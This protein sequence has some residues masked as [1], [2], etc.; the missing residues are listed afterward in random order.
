M[1]CQLTKKNG[2][3]VW[4]NPARVAYV[5]PIEEDGWDAITGGEGKSKTPLSRV[6]FGAEGMDYVEVLGTAEAIVGLL[7]MKVARPRG[8]SPMSDNNFACADCD[9][10]VF[11]RVSFVVRADLWKL[12]GIPGKGRML[13]AG[14]FE[15]RMGRAIR[16]E[17]LEPV[18]LNTHIV[19]DRFRKGWKDFCW[20]MLVWLD[21]RKDLR[22]EKKGA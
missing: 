21:E 18:P 14:C 12:H 19:H 4:V 9:T 20:L 22:E 1:F 11:G 8:M 7:M 15:K 10:G 6:S 13:C 17:D 3:D 2:Q 5:E 16:F